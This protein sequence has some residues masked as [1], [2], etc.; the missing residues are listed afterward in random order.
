[1]ATSVTQSLFGMNPQAIQAQRA[2]DLD[3]QAL[4]FAQLSPMQ[5]AQMGLFRAGSQLGTGIAGL[6]GFEDPEIAQA[7]Q[8]QGLLGGADMNDPDALMQ[9]AQR[10]QSINPAA[11]QELAQRA[12]AMQRTQAETQRIETDVAAKQTAAQREE[13]LR[14]ELANLPPE[15]TDQE[16]EAVVRKFGNPDQ[17]FK[18]IE[19]RQTAEAN[20]QA[21]AELEREKAAE[22]AIRAQEAAVLRQ[23]A[24]QQRQATTD[25][26]RERIQQQID[27]QQEKTAAAA[28]K[29]QMGLDMSIRH[30]NK[31]LDD[32]AA[33]KELVGFS[34]TGL[35]GKA[36]GVIPGTDAYNLNQRVL[37]LK[38]NLGFDRLQQMRDASPTGGALG[39]VAVQELE[40]L[41]ASVGS[42]EIGQ[43]QSELRNNLEKIQKHYTAWLNAVQGARG[44]EAQNVNTG[45]ASGRP[46]PTMRFNPATGKLEPI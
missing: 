32:V 43:S 21:R 37:T 6:M 5:Q 35:A 40:A 36:S 19:R 3:A 28:D 45:A 39:Q 17:L 10:L 38:A 24:L 22:R 14:T 41:Q 23:L 2:A 42:L 25:L 13:Q 26:Q 15:A 30:A 34:T 9:V 20:R 46:T 8:V 33:A 18:T 31:M 7:R 1:M 44:P 16:V 29:K 12:M 27:A 11:A 4:R